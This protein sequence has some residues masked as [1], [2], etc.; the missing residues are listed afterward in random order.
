M[1]RAKRKKKARKVV[2]V[3]AWCVVDNGK[4]VLATYSVPVYRSLRA[5]SSVWR[6]ESLCR[7]RVIVG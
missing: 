1:T 7:C 3:K 5:A 4:I 6:R 2:T